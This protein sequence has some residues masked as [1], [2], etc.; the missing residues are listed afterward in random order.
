MG[1][2]KEDDFYSEY[3]PQINHI[4]REKINPSINDRDITGWNGTMYE[5]FGEELDYITNLVRSGEGNRVWTIVDGE[6]GDLIIIAG[7]RFVNRMG[8][9]VTEKPWTSSDDYVEEEN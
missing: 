4:I 7:F 9:L 8:Y 3:K 2:I 5:T 1:I 6:D